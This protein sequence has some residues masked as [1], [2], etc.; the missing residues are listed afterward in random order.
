MRPAK[1][2]SDP[3]PP[4]LIPLSTPFRFLWRPQ[5]PRRSRAAKYAE[6]ARLGHPGPQP[7]GPDLL[8]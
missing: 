8:V 5:L 3:V 2:T 1:T 6:R 7:D 4:A